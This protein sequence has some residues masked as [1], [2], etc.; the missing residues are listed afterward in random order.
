[1]R[2]YDVL[3]PHASLDFPAT[4]NI[5]IHPISH[6]FIFYEYIDYIWKGAIAYGPLGKGGYG[7]DLVESCRP[8][9][10]EESGT[11]AECG[12]GARPNCLCFPGKRW[13]FHGVMN[14]KREHHLPIYSW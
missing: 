3:G 13:D 10:G 6:Q 9:L 2:F 5:E 7:L 11:V 12:I 1:M 8:L 14:R 4:K